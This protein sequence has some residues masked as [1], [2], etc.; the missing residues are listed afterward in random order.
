MGGFAKGG[1][2]GRPKSNPFGNRRTGVWDRILQTK[3]ASLERR[4]LMNPD[5]KE[6]LPREILEELIE[7]RCRGLSERTGEAVEPGDGD[8]EI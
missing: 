3:H 2:E 6:S 5:P 1:P 7:G 8:G 4:I